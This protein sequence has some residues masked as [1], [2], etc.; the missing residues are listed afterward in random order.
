[1]KRSRRKS[2]KARRIYAVCFLTAILAAYL[3]SRYAFQL[4]LIQGKSMEPTYA[5]F[6]LTLI[7][8][9]GSVPERGDV[10]FFNAPGL[11]SKLVKR[12]VGIPGDTLVIKNGHLWVNGD[13]PKAYEDLLF[14]EAGLLQS[15]MTLKEKEYFVLGD[16]IS[17]SKDSR[18]AEVGVIL[19]KDIIGKLI[20]Q[21]SI[22]E[23]MK[24][25][26]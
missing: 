26:R 14:D 3:F 2:S 13:I 10:I 7:D 15:E 22:K 12:V 16:N 11:K 1:M 19:E 4:L 23:K 25:D 21:R 17:E 18:S 20:P 8:K 6:S 9:R 5:S 24:D